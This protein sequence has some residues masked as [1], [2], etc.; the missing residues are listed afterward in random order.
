[1]VEP[2]P[3]CGAARRAAPGGV[4]AVEAALVAGASA[5]VAPDGGPLETLLYLPAI[6]VRHRLAGGAEP[7]EAM[8]GG[9]A[10]MDRYVPT[11]ISDAARPA[12]P[13]RITP[14]GGCWAYRPV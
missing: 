9:L 4:G 6:G 13:V 11:A 8:L 7:A 3:T 12:A 14:P 5:G 1:M 2:A 10:D